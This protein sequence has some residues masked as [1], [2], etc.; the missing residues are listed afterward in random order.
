MADHAADVVGLL[1]ALGLDQ[2]VLGGHYFGGMLA[3][4]MA[5]KYPERFSKL[6]IIDSAISWPS[7]MGI[8]LKT[9]WYMMHRIRAEVATDSHVLLQGTIEANET[10]VDGIPPQAQRKAKEQ[11]RTPKAGRGTKK[12]LVIGAL[13]WSG[14]VELSLRTI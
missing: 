7:D 14:K 12:T 4:Y 8:N 13:E 11:R 9:A 10:Y 3:L 6:V 2:V 1:D 5:A